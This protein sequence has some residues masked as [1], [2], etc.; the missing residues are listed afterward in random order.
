MSVALDRRGR[1]VGRV[2]LKTCF[3]MVLAAKAFIALPGLCL[4]PIALPIAYLIDLLPESKDTH[5]PWFHAV[6]DWV[7]VGLDR[8]TP[9]WATRYEFWKWRVESSYGQERLEKVAAWIPDRLFAVWSYGSIGVMSVFLMALSVSVVVFYVVWID[10]VVISFLSDLVSGEFV[11]NVGGSPAEPSNPNYSWPTMSEMVTMAGRLVWGVVL[12]YASIVGLFLLVMPGF[13][14]HEFGHFVQSHRRG[15]D[16]NS[17]GLFFFGPIPI[18]AFVDVDY[19]MDD[20]GMVDFASIVSSG[21][22]ANLL[23]AAVLF[24][25]VY[26]LPVDAYETAV[27]YASGGSL[28]LSVGVVLLALAVMEVV[29]A[30]FNSIPMGGSDGDLFTKAGLSEYYGISPECSTVGLEALYRCLVYVGVVSSLERVFG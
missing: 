2:L 1:G 5:H 9:G 17:Y 15:L 14:L 4:V 18:G 3:G 12:F 21:V 8:L 23:Y 29:M 11:L 6:R 20:V 25:V 7:D 30:V 13:V 27:M 10:W 28:D 22:S 16:F 24:C 19:E 26:L